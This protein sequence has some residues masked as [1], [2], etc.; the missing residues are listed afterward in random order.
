MKVLEDNMLSKDGFMNKIAI[1]FASDQDNQEKVG[2]VADACLAISDDDRCES[3]YK[4]WKCLEEE[5]KNQELV[6]L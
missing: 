5:A 1:K 2:K 6:L 4:I 3:A